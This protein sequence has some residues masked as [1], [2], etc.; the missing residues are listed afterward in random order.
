VDCGY[1]FGQKAKTVGSADDML[2]ENK[3][4]QEFSEFAVTL[5]I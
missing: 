1:D 5:V 4:Y 3:Q 2:K